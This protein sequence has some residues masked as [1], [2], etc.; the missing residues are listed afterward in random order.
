MSFHT[1]I[2]MAWIQTECVWQGKDLVEN[3]TVQ[4]LWIALIEICPPTSSYQ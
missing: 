2:V 4:C 3:G 1:S